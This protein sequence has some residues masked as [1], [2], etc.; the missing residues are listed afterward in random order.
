MVALSANNN[1]SDSAVARDVYLFVRRIICL[2]A[3]LV[4]CS[5]RQRRH[6]QGA[7]GWVG[8]GAKLARR[9]RRIGASQ[10]V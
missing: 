9:D 6:W 7:P 2:I 10:T 8:A 1:L 3:P 4:V 5:R